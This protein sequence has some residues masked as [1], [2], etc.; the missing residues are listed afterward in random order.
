M[1]NHIDV[2][3]IVEGK[4]EQIFIRELLSPYLAPQGIYLHPAIL[5]T[6]GK[7]GGDVTFSLV[8]K[9]IC[10]HLKQRPDTYIT[11]MI[12]Y[13]GIKKIK[14]WPGLAESKKQREH[15]QKA[16]IINEETAKKIQKDLPDQNREHRFIPYVSMH[17]TE[18]LYFC[19]PATIAEALNIKQTE[20]ESILRECGEPEAINDNSETAPSK[21]LIKLSHDKYRKT[22]IGIAMAKRIGIPRMRERCPLFNEW[23]SKMENLIL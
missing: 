19:D 14:E 8:Q 16:Q 3:V 20:I 2:M 11:L 13:Y 10:N 22:T 12:D 9:D 1:N 15:S 6:V 4:T 5:G 7:K 18:A 21:R 17:E 23:I